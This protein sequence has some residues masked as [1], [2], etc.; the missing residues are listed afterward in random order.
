M[1]RTV[2]II[3]LIASSLRSWA[4]ADT[5]YDSALDR[6]AEIC[7]RITR[8]QA[9]RKSGKT[10]SE[11]QMKM[12]ASQISSLKETL[13]GADGFLSDD[14]R[15]RFTL[16]KDKFILG[17]TLTAVDPADITGTVTWQMPSGLHFPAP[18]EKPAPEPLHWAFTVMPIVTYAFSG[19]PGFMFGIQ[20]GVSYGPIGIYARGA[21]DF[22]PGA[23]SYECLS[24][25][26][27]PGGGTVWTSGVQR[28][29]G[30]NAAAGLTYQI[31]GPLSVYAGAGY[32]SRSLIWEDLEGA[33]VLVRDA[34]CKGAI[35]DIGV[36]INP[37]S[38]H[39]T[40]LAL[41]AGISV[42]PWTMVAASFG[43]GLRF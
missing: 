42:L 28:K 18:K 23:Y 1:R 14:Q 25:G 38:R 43:I 30:W 26:S 15:L 17:N 39:R 37:K 16:I 33:A 20:A 7:N 11:G 21:T 36:L 4:Q 24:D 40:S 3:I 22:S 31:V 5:L 34:S 9:A 8:F 19:V 13:Q 10:V 2:L 12:L 41:L 27:L 35:A 29:S 6:Y 32:A